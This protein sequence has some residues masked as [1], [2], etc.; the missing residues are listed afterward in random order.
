MFLCICLCRLYIRFS[1]RLQVDVVDGVSHWVDLTGCGQ[2]IPVITL[3]TLPRR[4]RLGP[5]YCG[6]VACYQFTI[7]NKGRRQQTVFATNTAA[8]AAAAALKSSKRRVT[9]L[10]VQCPLSVVYFTVFFSYLALRICFS[11]GSVATQLRCG[12]MV[13]N[14]IIANCLQS[15]PVKNFLIGQRS[16]KI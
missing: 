5:V 6:H 2:G 15:E 14:H 9:S 4:L 16:S 13:N 12:G 7:V 3:P 8:A 11:H 1:D 10:F